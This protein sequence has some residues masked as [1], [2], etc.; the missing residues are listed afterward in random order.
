MIPGSFSVGLLKGVRVCV[1]CVIIFVKRITCGLKG[2]RTYSRTEKRLSGA[3]H[4]SEMS[5]GKTR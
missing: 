2:Y 1:H 3:L 5:P 4:L